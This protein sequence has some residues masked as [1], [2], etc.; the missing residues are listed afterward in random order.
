MAD[1]KWISEL[2]ADTPLADAARRV[3]TVRLDVVHHYLPL[4]VRESAKDSEYVHQ[5]RVGTRRA[6]AALTIFRE[7]LPNKEYRRARKELKKIRRAAGQARDWDVFIL[8]LAEKQRQAP[9]SHR[10]GLDFLVGFAQAQRNLAQVHLEETGPD[11]PFYLERLQADTIASISTPD[12]GK[13][14]SLRQLAR[15]MLA[16][17]FA[18]LDESVAQDLSDYAHLHR[19]RIIGKRL[20]YA[21][22]VFAACF[23]PTFKDQLY[24]AVEEMQEVLGYANDSHVAVQRLTALRDNLR[25]SWPTQWK[26]FRP[27]VESLLQ[28]H[29]RRLPQER[30]RFLTW[31]K[32][33]QA[34]GGKKAFASLIKGQRLNHRGMKEV[35]SSH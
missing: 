29:Q 27:G 33:W 14:H 15:P 5:L 7:S 32:N 35:K 34:S 13:V 25:E 22:E 18:E 24:P 28:F 30:K 16:G 23:D 20:R 8:A 19:V 26:R 17:L 4:A 1:G 6:G 21:M 3:L 10:R 2:T 31:W 12:N 11:Y 9:P